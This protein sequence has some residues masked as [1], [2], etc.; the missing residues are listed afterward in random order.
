M[1][2]STLLF[3]LYQALT[4]HGQNLVL[5][6]DFEIFDDC[7]KEYSRTYKK[8]V[9][10]NWVSPTQGTPDYFNSCSK[11]LAGVPENWA[12]YCEA[13]SGKGY[14]GMYLFKIGG[15]KEHVQGML[16]TA[17]D[18]GNKYKIGFRIYQSLNAEY[19]SHQIHVLLSTLSITLD[20]SYNL[21]A[22]KGAKLTSLELSIN[23]ME[24]DEDWQELTF[25]YIANGGEKFIT[26]GN[27][28]NGLKPRW[29]KNEYRFEQEYMLNSSSYVYI[30]N[31]FVLD[32]SKKIPITEKPLKFVL[33]ELNFETNSYVLLPNGMNRLDSLLNSF[34]FLEYSVSISGHADNIG[35]IN[36]NLELSSK[37]SN[38]VYNYL[39]LNGINKDDIIIDN[40]GELKPVSSNETAEGRKN[41]RRVELTFKKK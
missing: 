21:T 37:R 11:G 6:P 23:M 13:F 15:Y 12:G 14:I 10:K 31:V 28:D 4:L 7:P 18:S 41:N 3:V 34:L 1:K 26:I 16:K 20:Y 40:H 25:D 22:P 39:M 19:L 5:N 17:L 30:D 36:Y 8:E 9:I 2:K 29:Q 24:S 35:S 33:N 38:S 27:F 32:S